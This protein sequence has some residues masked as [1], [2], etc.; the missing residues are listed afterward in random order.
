MLRSQIAAASLV[1][2]VAVA[3]AVA[4]AV[5]VVNIRFITIVRIL[6]TFKT[7]RFLLSH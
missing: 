1:V 6:S 4:V 3:V 2:V 7:L 5:V